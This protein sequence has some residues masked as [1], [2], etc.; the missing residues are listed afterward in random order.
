MIVIK[1][2]ITQNIYLT[3]SENQETPSEWYYFNFVNRATNEVIQKW[4]EN[5]SIENNYQMFSVDGT[6]FESNNSGFYTYQIWESNE[7]E[8]ILGS[9]LEHGYMELENGSAFEPVKY[10]DQNNLFKTYN[11]Q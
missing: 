7:E 8:E 3:L 10:T 1:K 6:D 9:V 4:Y 11:G 2:N 5:I